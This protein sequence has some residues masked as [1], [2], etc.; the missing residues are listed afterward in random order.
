MATVSKK[1]FVNLCLK[2]DLNITKIVKELKAKF[3][4]YGAR[5]SRVENR[6]ETMRKRGYLPLDSGNYVSVGEI[7]KGTTTLFGANG[8]IKHQYVKTDVEKTTQLHMFEDALSNFLEKLPAAAAVSPPKLK[9]INQNTLSVYT[10]GD[11]HLGLFSWKPET[12]QDYSLD[13]AQTDLLKAMSLLVEQSTTSEEA[14]IID[15]GDYFHSDN[16][17][18]KTAKSGNPLD[19]EGR[20]A[21][22]LE[23][24]LDLT[25]KLIDQALLKHKKVHWRSAVGNHNEHSAL[26]INKFIKTYY[27]DNPRVIVHDTPSMFYYHTFG[28]NLVGVTHGHTVK[29]EKLGELMAVDCEDIWS[30]SKYRYWYTGHI[31]HQSVK[32]YPSCVVETFR[33][34]TAKDA[35][36]SSAGYRSGQDMKCITLHKDFG[37]ISR[38]TVNV[39]RLRQ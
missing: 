32:E 21:Q 14:F 19:V 12:G 25:V 22:I 3:P 38:N 39:H 18:N 34:L 10:I 27:R 31:H 30:S 6:I 9:D 15:V 1:E 26:M 29:A 20:Y 13:L 37:E 7:L 16:N 11:A 28:K 33:T 36:H 5:A 4:E 2:H 24:G 17:E 8:E 23:I 35:W